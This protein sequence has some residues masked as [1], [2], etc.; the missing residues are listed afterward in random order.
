GYDFYKRHSPPWPLRQ[1]VGHVDLPRMRE[2][3]LR[4]QFFAMWTFPHPER[5]CAADVHRQIDAL[6]RTI[7]AGTGL[8]LCR[9][10][11]EGRAVRAADK[12]A[13]LLGLE[14]G[15]ALERGPAAEVVERL[16]AFARRGVR[17]LGI[18]HLSPNALCEPQ[19]G[20]RAGER[21]GL[22]AL[23]C[24]VVDACA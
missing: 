5:G 12:T 10:A 11:D 3:N 14:G 21:R 17:Y 8:V 4:A 9:S 24:E 16:T 22:S 23:G 6:E 7:A 20:F 13:A 15:Q 1:F 2:G 19:Y 18:A